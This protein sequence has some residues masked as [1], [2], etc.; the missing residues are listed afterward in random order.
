MY[1]LTFLSENRQL[2]SIFALEQTE[3]AQTILFLDILARLPLKHVLCIEYVRSLHGLWFVHQK[4]FF[5][6]F[7]SA[8]YNNKSFTSSRFFKSQRQSYL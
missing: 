6:A 8:N 2:K 1:L 3:I 4:D 7:V 5:F